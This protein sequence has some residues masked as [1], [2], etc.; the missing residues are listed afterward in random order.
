MGCQA[1]LLGQP[2]NARFSKP[3][4]PDLANQN[5][6]ASGKKRK[7]PWPPGLKSTKTLFKSL[8]AFLTMLFRYAPVTLEDLR[9]LNPHERSVLVHIFKTKRYK[10]WSQLAKTIRLRSTKLAPWTHFA[11]TRRK[12]ENLKY[13]FKLVIR[14]LQARF[15]REHCR[16]LARF[17]AE[18]KKLVFYLFHFYRLATGKPYE[19]VL[20]Q[21]QTQADPNR[22]LRRLW[23]TVQNYI[24]PEM[25]TQSSF[26]RVKSIS[27]QF[28]SE[29]VASPSMREGFLEVIVDVALFLCCAGRPR[30]ELAPR[31]RL[32]SQI[33]WRGRE[34]LALI[35]KTNRVE[36]DKLFA[37]WD[38]RLLWH[39]RESDGALSDERLV[40]VVK[41]T[42]RR[43][44]FKFPWTLREVQNSFA[45]TLLVYLEICQVHR[46]R[47]S[48]AGGS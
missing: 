28:L 16:S 35:H 43:K 46:L 44:N 8:K 23:R 45:D 13:S 42:I 6:K 47:R 29:F 7:R 18:T 38:N 33:D 39:A 32:L 9:T 40:R 10:N 11:K 41:Q 2:D 27:K 5:P 25:G 20:E 15:G 48:N 4:Q 24:L 17:D 36:I 34:V 30:P 26:S 12:E 37:E 21:L 3:N 22:N 14:L 1:E 31:P 19:S